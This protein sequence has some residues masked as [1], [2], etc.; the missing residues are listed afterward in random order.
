MSASV[1][2]V[3]PQRT[4]PEPVSPLNGVFLNATI[5]IAEA[6]GVLTDMGLRIINVQMA[7]GAL[8]TIHIAECEAL[9]ER[10]ERD[11]AAY[12]HWSTDESTGRQFRHGQF[13][14]RGVR[15]IWVEQIGH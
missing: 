3:R 8:P 12:Y 2:Y 9:R 4:V 6:V 13:Q 5:A 11:E 10:V 15:C 7:W 14:I 1:S